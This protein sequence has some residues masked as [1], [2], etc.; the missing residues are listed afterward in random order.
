MSKP[1]IAQAIDHEYAQK[2]NSGHRSH[3][4]ISQ[5][6]KE[7]DRAVWYMFNKCKTIVHEGRMLRLFQFGHDAEQEFAKLLQSVGFR[8]YTEN[9]QTGEQWHVQDPE[10]FFFSGSLDTVAVS[11]DDIEFHG[12]EKNTPYII[13]Y[14]TVSQTSFNQFVKH[15]L[16]KWRIEYYAQLQCYMGFSDQLGKKPVRKAMIFV[17]NKNNHE[18]HTE[19]VDFNPDYFE[20]MREKA[21]LIVQSEKPPMRISD[22]PDNFKCRFCDYKDICHDG[23]MSEP[24]CRNCG[25]CRKHLVHG[26]KCDKGF[27]LK[28]C[29]NHVY[30]P[31]LLS[32]DFQIL[33]F[34]PEHDA[35]E[36]DG[37][38]NA[39]F[40]SKD[41]FGDKPVV[42]S[43]ELYELH[44]GNKDQDLIDTILKFCGKFDASVEW[45]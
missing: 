40:K 44:K 7:C 39:P 18:I 41:K 13:D 27:N 28:P 23:F 42:N 1:T 29:A 33:E 31:F 12:V 9:P 21:K 43:K 6:G 17:F 45:E 8:V 24:S 14:K 15:G 10:N 34:H 3:I 30:N 4:G 19:C 25:F 37:F 22:D 38:V 20:A 11:P 32:E 35:M 26:E 5:I 16:F 2:N 36:Y